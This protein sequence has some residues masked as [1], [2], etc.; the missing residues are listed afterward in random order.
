MVSETTAISTYNCLA[1]STDALSLESGAYSRW[2]TLH[3]EITLSMNITETQFPNT[4]NLFP[5]TLSED[6]FLFWT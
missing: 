2:L 5:S 1:T 3:L 6:H 4:P